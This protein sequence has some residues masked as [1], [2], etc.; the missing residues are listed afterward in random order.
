MKA[1]E[2]A[3]VV[4]AGAAAGAVGL[5]ATSIAGP[6]SADAASASMDLY[7]R[8]RVAN[9]GLV[10]RPG[11][12]VGV[13]LLLTSE[14]EGLVVPWSA[15]LHDINGGTWVYVLSGE[16]A[17]TRTRVE[18]ADVVDGLALLRRGPPDGSQVVSVGAAELFST[19]FGTSH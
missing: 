15:V 17:Y 6:P 16:H 3:T 2:P 12:R 4:A 13:S 1:G 14:A 8:Y 19:E 11:E 9:P 5:P 10:L 7:Y 18:V